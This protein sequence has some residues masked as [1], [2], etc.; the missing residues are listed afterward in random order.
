MRNK[1]YF[2]LFI[3]M[4]FASVTFAQVTVKGT[5]TDK[6]DN[7]P[8]PGVTVVIQNTTRGTITDIN[9]KYELK[10]DSLGQTLQFKFVGMETITMVAT[11]TTVNAG[12]SAGVELDAVVVT[13]LGI[14]KQKKAL[15][16]ATQEVQGEDLNNVKYDNVVNSMSGRVAGA[17]VKQSGNF[18]GST[19]IVLRGSTSLVGNNQALFVVDGVPLDNANVNSTSQKEGGKGYDYGN[20]VSDINPDDIESMNVLKGAAATALYGER[21]ANG[22]VMITTKSGSGKGKKGI[23]ATFS[24]NYTFGKV[25][26]STFPKYQDQYGA[27]YGPYYSGGTKPGLEEYDFNGD[28]TDDFVT[29]FTED[30]SMGQ[31]FDGSPVYQWDALVPESENYNKATP[32]QSAGDNGAISFFE[33]AQSFTNSL[34]LQGGDDKTTFRASY[35]NLSQKGILPNSQLNRNNIAV[36]ASHQAT[37]KLSVNVNAN[38]VSTKATGRN[39]SGYSDNIMSSYRQWWQTNVD[40]TQLKSL[41][42]KTDRNVTWNPAYSGGS[43]ST[44]PIY[45]DNP[46]W[47]R[48]QNYQND[49]RDRIFGN[50]SAKY[51]FT[52]NF[53]AM[54]RFTVDNYS[55]IREERRAV[56]S[57]STPF[58]VPSAGQVTPADQ[59]SGYYRSDRRFNENNIDVILTYNKDINSD[60]NLNVMGGTNYRANK[61]TQVSASTNGGLT[62]PG[63]YALTN[64]PSQINSELEEEIG[65]MGVYAAATLGYKSY[66]FVDVSA[67]NDW[68]STLQSDQRSYFYPA[69]S[70][71]FV[72]SELMDSKTVSFGKVRVNL[73]Q[74]GKGAQFGVSGNT[75]YSL[76]IAFTSPLATAGVAKYN[77]DLR[78]ERTNSFETGLEMFFLNRRVGFDLAYYKTNSKDQIVSVPVSYATGYSS[79]WLN[80]GELQNQGVEL[81]L[82]GTAMDKKDF[83]WD[84]SINWSKNVNKVISLEEGIDN[85]QL[86]SFQGGITVNA[87]V[88]ESYG[89]ISGSDYVYAPDGS[90][91][92][93]AS[94]YYE[95]S[96]TNDNVIGN[97]TPDFNAGMTNTFSYKNWGMSFLIDWQQGGDIFSLDQWYGMGTGLYEETAYTN[98]KGNPVR[99]PVADGG[100]L[101]LD[102]VVADLD[103]SGNPTGTYSP[104]TNRVEGGDYRVNGWSRNPNSGFIYDASYVK[105]RELAVLY[106][107]PKT[108]LEKTFIANATLSFVGSNLWIIHKNLPHADP[109][110]GLSSGNLQGFQSGVLPTTRNFGFNLKM[111]F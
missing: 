91:V 87:R 1:N 12:M 7:S 57:I 50:I 55:L 96:S 77:T 101:I 90:K 25:D 110:A 6:D 16:Y 103:G 72:F 32:W 4:L 105:L 75:P 28:G 5:V 53:N 84:V 102:G 22:V 14:S 79:K 40:V 81:T 93:G 70:G 13:A 82:M 23:G 99:S 86:G 56:G 92:V 36:S 73:A 65:V 46:Y 37:D 104:N 27:G 15:G 10:I 60:F 67:R 109:E 100:G 44:D 61:M 95:I 34:S 94:G 20:A 80:A 111:N 19:N 42:E 63:L 26:K 66:L 45:W 62:V 108:L 76:P 74:V 2:L 89:A 9:G 85:L 41:Y 78:P 38:Y 21:A 71:S 17:S 43:G 39:S 47:S 18:G 30:G 64:A 48:H 33:T 83:K 54:V 51:K 88:G 8:L 58:G 29:P 59:S 35:R 31:A 69:V 107:L 3:G 52:D 11:G 68:S 97:I 49:S 98:D 106:T 24:S